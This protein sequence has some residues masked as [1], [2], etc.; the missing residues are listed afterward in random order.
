MQLVPVLSQLSDKLLRY[1]ERT[2]ARTFEFVQKLTEVQNVYDVTKLQTEFIQAQVQAMYELVSALGESPTKA[3]MGG[4]KTP[5][6][7]A[8]QPTVTLKHIAGALAKRHGIARMRMDKLLN[9]AIAL[10]ADHLKKG[11]RIR[12]IGLGTFQVRNRAARM[13]RN[14]A[15]GE[16]IAIK[17]SKAVEFRASKQLNAEIASAP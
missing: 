10:I 5:T 11:D 6:F 7:K 3:T 17:A 2:F 9:G 8:A 4:A 15:T 14:P 12:I 1:I 13:G 16:Q